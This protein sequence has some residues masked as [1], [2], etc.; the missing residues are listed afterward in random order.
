MIN[1]YENELI[2]FQLLRNLNNEKLF[3][4]HCLLVELGKI[5]KKEIVNFK[6]DSLKNI[7]DMIIK[8]KKRRNKSQIIPSSN[9]G[10][11]TIKVTYKFDNEKMSENKY[12]KLFDEIFVKN[13]KENIWAS[14]NKR[15]K[16]ELKAYYRCSED[17]KEL[18][19]DLI[20]KEGKKIVDMSYMFNNCKNLESVDFSNFY[21]TNVTSMEAM[22]QL[23]PL[24]E[25]KIFESIKS[26]KTDNLSNIRAMFCKCI[27]I[28]SVPELSDIF[29][30]KNNIIE[31]ISMLFNGCINLR[32]IETIN[33]IF[34]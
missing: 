7:H 12:I 17:E 22:F 11:G 6:F 10:G 18:N 23:C 33:Q 2:N 13:N 8:A 9:E 19:I 21:T 29:F 32:T 25:K 28:N 31:N 20:E 3:E 27:Q 34:N 1:N 14:I 24:E 30:S 15:E 26:F 16:K 5:Y 4:N